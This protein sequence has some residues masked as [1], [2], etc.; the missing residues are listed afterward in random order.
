L[1]QLGCGD[2]SIAKSNEALAAAEA[3]GHPFS[4]AIALAYRGMLHVFRRESPAALVWAEQ[5]SAVGRK[6]EFA[7]YLSMAEI[8]AGWALA[9]EGDAES[10]MARLRRGLDSLK[11][12]GAEVRLPFYHGLLAE[13]CAL[14]R[15]PG[16]ALANISNGLAFQNKNGEMWAASDLHRIHG[17]LLLEGGHPAQAQASYQRAIE[18]ARLTGA[19]SWELRA[20][21][22]L[23]RLAPDARS[24]LESLYL[25]FTEGFETHDLRDAERQFRPPQNALRTPHMTE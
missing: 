7:Y 15:L 14:A 10:G 25:Q 6:H 4:R 2:Q 5:A 8:V 3:V 16:E 13:V 9:M 17:D 12:T 23:C 1:W 19:R 24:A 22:R 21:T 11:A 20:A 18:A